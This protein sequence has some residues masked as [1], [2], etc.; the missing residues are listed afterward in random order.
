MVDVVEHLVEP[1]GG[2]VKRRMPD[3]TPGHVVTSVG[4]PDAQA[5][6]CAGLQRLHHAVAHRGVERTLGLFSTGF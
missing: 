5:L 3:Q 2:L 4:Q 6:G 1:P